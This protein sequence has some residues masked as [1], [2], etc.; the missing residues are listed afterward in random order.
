MIL[1][2][3]VLPV[4]ATPLMLL[5][6]WQGYPM[7]RQWVPYDRISPS[8]ARAV[9]AA[10]D[11][12]FCVQTLGFD[13]PALRG[14]I[15]AWWGGQRPRGASTLTMQTAKNLMLWPGRDP[16]RKVV[17][18]WLTPQIALIWPRKRVLE[19]YLNIVEFGPG[20][21]GAEAAARAHFRKPASALSPQ[22][23]A[24]LAVVLPN[25]LEWSASRPTASLLERAR[26]VR[27]RVGQ[28]GPLLDCVE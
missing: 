3:L 26:V 4:P 20:L 9:I 28:L 19:V 11:N 17:E 13:L 24:Q 25:P 22:E 5:R 1:A 2:A 15:G 14:E 6:S 7:Q 23:A 10:E 18:A 12:F 27:Q 21:Y 8:L 16:V